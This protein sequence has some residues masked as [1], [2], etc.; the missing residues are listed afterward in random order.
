MSARSLLRVI[1]LGLCSA[2]A[3]VLTP[4]GCTAPGDGAS[5]EAENDGSQTGV[6]A[7]YVSDTAD[8]QSQ[9]LYF[10]RDAL[11][12][13]RKLLFDS[14]PT[15]APNDRIKLWAVPSGDALHVTSYLGLPDAVGETPALIGATPFAARSFAFVLVDIG[16]GINTTSAAVQGIMMTNPESI[17]NY[18]L[19]DSYAMQDIAATVFGPITY[20]LPDCSNASTSQLATDLRPMIPGT[21]QHYLWY[22]G[23]T[24]SAC[25]WSGLASLGTPAKPSRDTWYNASTSC[26]VLVQEPGHNFGMQHSS[27]LSCPG[28]SFADDPNTCTAS[29]YGDVFDPMGSSCRHMNAWQKSYQGWLSACN[30]VKVTSTGTFNLVPFEEQCSGVQFLQ[31]Q[32]PKARTFMRPAGGGGN[33]T[34]EN[35]AYYYVEL[36][37]PNDFDGTLGNRSALAP[38]VLIHVADNLRTRT[39]A[40]DHTFLLDM[41][42]ATTG[43]TAFSDA[44]LGVGQTFTDP[45][46]GVSITVQSLSATGATIVVTS[47]VNSAAP[48]CMDGTTFAPPGPT[49]SSCTGAGGGAGGAGGAGGK[50]GSGGSTGA[51]GA[52]GA[53]GGSGGSTGAGGAAGAKGG[54]TGAGGAAGAKGGTTGTTGAGGAA[55]AK[56]GSG[57]TGTTGGAGTTGSTGAAGTTGG[58]AA[59]ASGSTGAAG[60]TDVAGTSGGAAGASGAAGTTGTGRAGAGGTSSSG[61]AG[62][63]ATQTTG[64]AGSVGTTGGAASGGCACDTSGEAPSPAFLF[65]LAASG[66]ILLVR[67]RRLGRPDRVHRFPTGTA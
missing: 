1:S 11:G 25:G 13:E 32:A 45:A 63:G 19:D 51:G 53:K 43:R 58:G 42:P 23:S 37:T 62:S 6:L 57:G 12:H 21:F 66:M 44:G 52:A 5:A 14:A 16:G 22:F 64:R 4:S 34:T 54:S 7:V 24:N 30:G 35:L 67:R 10:L 33:A 8:G 59:G 47:S 3:L 49:V 39:Q 55:G 26:V 50:G 15:V 9:T 46:G 18:Y 48:T 17:R 27:S 61:Q 65:S 29:E 20:T 38:T 41:T 2:A 40:G 36:R 60:A 56:G 31:I 28:A